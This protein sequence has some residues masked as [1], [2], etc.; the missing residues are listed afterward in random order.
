[1]ECC[2]S[3]L[4]SLQCLQGITTHNIDVLKWFKKKQV[5]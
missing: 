3:T 4:E 5:N 2:L 1:M